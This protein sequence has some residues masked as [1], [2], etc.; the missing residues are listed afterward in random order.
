LNEKE[1]YQQFKDPKEMKRK[2]EMLAMLVLH[3][4]SKVMMAAEF[5]TESNEYWTPDRLAL[6][7]EMGVKTLNEI[8]ISKAKVTT[9]KSLEQMKKDTTMWSGKYIG[10]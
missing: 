3:S 1:F 4:Y 7:D 6:L 10:V 2:F 8:M 5:F 9:I